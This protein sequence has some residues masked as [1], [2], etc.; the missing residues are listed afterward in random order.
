MNA[1]EN[2]NK[3]GGIEPLD[4]NHA[5]SNEI[6]KKKSQFRVVWH[7]YG[8]SKLAIFGLIV[9]SLM[10]ILVL[11]ADLYMDYDR[12]ALEMHIGNKY[13]APNKDNWFGTDQF[14]RDVLAR[15]IFG[16][17]ISMFVGVATVVISLTFGALI[18]ATAAYF[19]G[20]LD[21][22]LM[23]IMDV[24]LAIPGTL[25]AITIIS[26]LGSSMMNLLVAMGISQTPRMSR[27]VRS[28]V[29]GVKEMDFIEAAKA[30]GTGNMRV[31]F[32]HILP[33]AMGPILVQASQTVAR[34]VLIVASLSFVGLGIAEPTPEWGS[35]LSNVKTMMRNYPYLAFA[36]GIAMVL[37]VLSLTLIG[38]GLRDAM[39]PRLRN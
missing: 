13:Q 19:G 14:G 6:Y 38:D 35:M 5:N 24:F 18:G 17:R 15:V 31:I 10:L 39:D 34:S 29:L 4:A 25:L 32:R 26:A 8:R 23:R 20:R 28:A 3:G 16:G 27:I 36:P 12:D 7:R 30:C 33:N 22:L 11:T 37:S 1:R 2:H 9:F 21:N